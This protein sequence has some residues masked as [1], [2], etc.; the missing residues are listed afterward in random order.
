MIRFLITGVSSGIGR[1]LVKRLI[2]EGNMVWGVARRQGLLEDLRKELCSANFFYSEMDIS[3]RK[4]WEKLAGQMK[5]AD[6]VPD[7]TI[8]NAAINKND[9]V[10]DLE[11]DLTRE[12][13][14]INL[15]GA[16]EGIKVL[17]KFVNPKAE[18]M[19]ISS[20]SALKGSGVEGIGYPASKAALSIAFESLYQKFKNKYIFKT[21]YFG[22][23][24]TGMVPFRKN[25]LFLL[26]EKQAVSKIIQA[27]LGKKVIYYYP[28]VLFFILKT[29]R[30]FPSKIY[31]YLLSQIEEFHKKR[32]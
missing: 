26:S 18:F 20:S 17:L 29:I 4:E 8:F 6:F 16:L 30:H 23:I 7:K 31:F 13:F 2:N 19:A 24:N 3:K 14:D 9:F 12:M 27:T 28:G 22:P 10:N 25:S 21:I 15:F 5:K 32:C 1:A 11:T